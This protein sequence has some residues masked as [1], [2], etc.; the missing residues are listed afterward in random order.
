MDLEKINVVAMK[1][2]GKSHTVKLNA[3]SYAARIVEGVFKLE[4]GTRDEL[5][6]ILK[7]GLDVPGVISAAL[8]GSVAEGKETPLSD[9]DL[10]VITNHRERMEEVISHLQGEVALRFGN[11]LMP[12]YL[13]KD[14]FEGKRDTSLVKQILENHVLIY[15]KRL[16]WKNGVK[17]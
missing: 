5:K 9:I 11:T 1:T 12:Y 4:E 17:N 3:A 14:E 10:L 7:E 8:F 16:A 13:S 15:G 2:L 6:R